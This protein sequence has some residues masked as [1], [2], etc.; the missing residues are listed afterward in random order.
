MMKPLCVLA[1]LL[2]CLL[3]LVAPCFARDLPEAL[4][5]NNLFRGSEEI[6][7][8]VVVEEGLALRRYVYGKLE[9]G[10]IL[11]LGGL[12]LP[13]FEWGD[14]RL[15]WRVPAPGDFVCLVRTIAE[16]GGLS[17]C[18]YGSLDCFT[19]GM[20]PATLHF[21]WPKASDQRGRFN[22]FLNE[23]RYLAPTASK[24]P[25]PGEVRPAGSRAGK[26]N[27]RPSKARRIDSLAGPLVY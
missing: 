13:Y 25:P 16:D 6:L 21:L 11:P 17:P 14:E 15:R 2:F 12:E 4:M 19:D 7:L 22:Q 26:G 10:I 3:A 20:D 18:G 8:C 1:A 9:E 23:G 5:E 24:A 27:M